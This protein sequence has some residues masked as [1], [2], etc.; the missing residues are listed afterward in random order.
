MGQFDHLHAFARR[1]G[2]AERVLRS[3]EG[4]FAGHF[5]EYLKLAIEVARSTLANLRPAGVEPEAWDQR[6]QKVSGMIGCR[7]V[8]PTTFRF[9]IGGGR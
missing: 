1:I 6:I 5:D 2:D 3:A 4:F 9:R 7:L 8:S